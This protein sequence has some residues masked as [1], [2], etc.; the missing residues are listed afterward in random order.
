[1]SRIVNL[2]LVCLV[3][4]PLKS[5]AFHG[6]EEATEASE[7]TT[8]EWLS[9]TTSVL[10]T[11]G[12]T[13]GAIYGSYALSTKDDEMAQNYIKERELDI[14]TG[15]ATGEGPFVEEM[16]TALKVE[17]HQRK[18]FTQLLLQRYT[19]LTELASADRVTP[20]RARRFFGTIMEIRQQL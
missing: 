9:S 4:L 5:H 15:L 3:L 10:L 19:E 20:D 8:G 16:M 17:D 13:A 12:T 7:P 11:L 6:E 2:F 18:R 14:A 1:M